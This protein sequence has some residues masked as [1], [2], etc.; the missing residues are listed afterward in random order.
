MQLLKANQNLVILGGTQK[1]RVQNKVI[2]D[3]R[4]AKNGA[5]NMNKF[6]G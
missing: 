6:F 4:F 1:L 3:K 5:T 2:E